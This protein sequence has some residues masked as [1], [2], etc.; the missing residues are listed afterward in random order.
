M[1]PYKICSLAIVVA[2]C[3]HFL[4]A[5]TL[6]HVGTIEFTVEMAVSVVSFAVRYITVRLCAPLV[7]TWPLAVSPVVY[8]LTFAGPRSS[9]H[10]NDWEVIESTTNKCTA[11]HTQLYT[12]PNCG[13][14]R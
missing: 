9:K 6:L 1:W 3:L 11:R 8:A 2:S 5:G 7:P 14:E 10:C 4:R 12:F 13:L